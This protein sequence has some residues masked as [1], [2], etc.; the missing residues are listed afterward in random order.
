MGDAVA[1]HVPPVTSKSFALL[2]VMLS[3]TGSE[4]PDRLVS[5]TVL[6]FVG[7]FDVSV[8]YASVTGATVAGIVG[9]VLSAME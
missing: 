5:V 2:P 3:L 7:I 1:V 9:A 6:V 4:N 8:P